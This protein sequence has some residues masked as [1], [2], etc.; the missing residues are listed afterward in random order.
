VSATPPPPLRPPSFPAHTQ[1]AE[2]ELPEEGQAI[3]RRL[4]EARTWQRRRAVTMACYD[5]LWEWDE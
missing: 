4:L 3:L 1:M 5:A 2:E